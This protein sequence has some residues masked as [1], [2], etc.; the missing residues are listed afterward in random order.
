MLYSYSI[1][2]FLL[3]TGKGH[4]VIQF[5]F[6]GWLDKL[7]PASNTAAELMSMIDEIW[8]VQYIQYTP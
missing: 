4:K 6:H 3:Q 2:L 1:Y 5:Q 8:K 7:P